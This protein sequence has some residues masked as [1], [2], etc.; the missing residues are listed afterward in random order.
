M[1]LEE[2]LAELNKLDRAQVVT[3][4]QTHAQP[5]YQAIFDKGHSTSTAANSAKVTELN[6][7]LA[8]LQE[9]IKAKDAEITQLQSKTPGAE[10]LRRTYE[11]QV[12]DLQKKNKE[13]TDE[14]KA[15]LW[16][17]RKTRVQT[18]L[19]MKLVSQGV[20]ADYAAVLVLKP[21]VQKRIRKAPETG[22]PEILQ[23]D[24]GVPLAAP[25]GQ[26]PLDVLVGEL[27]AAA[28]AKFKTVDSD[29]G[30][31]TDSG[32]PG[33]GKGNFFE[34]I[35]KDAKARAEAATTSNGGKSGMERLGIPTR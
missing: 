30:S 28:P 33:G 1:T 31:S 18:D 8:S 2:L 4:I 21:E 24:G 29:R 17:E 15:T 25:A 11:T 20:D 3:G 9:Q 22:Q 16:E 12:A 5:L 19:Q 7:T 6:G 32:G 14:L 34:G 23:A 13:A 26:T 35:R 27:S 10:E